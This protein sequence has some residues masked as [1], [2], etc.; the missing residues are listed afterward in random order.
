MSVARS[1]VV[2]AGC[3]KTRLLRNTRRSTQTWCR[4]QHRPQA[5]QKGCPAR[6]QQAKRR[7]VLA[8]YG[9]LLSAART[10][11]ADFFRS[12]LVVFMGGW[13]VAACAPPTPKVA[14]SVAPAMIER[15]RVA[16]VRQQDR[17]FQ[18]MV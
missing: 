14:P 8:P 9:E 4:Y 1:I 10:P 5:A 3:G 11:L 18:P 13:S 12:L 2:L 7:I 16:P 15:E 17:S 6:P